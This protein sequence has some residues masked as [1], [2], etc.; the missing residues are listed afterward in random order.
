MEHI[1]GTFKGVRNLGIYY[2]GWLP[3]GE[4]RAVVLIV[5][6]LGEHSGRYA[7][8][9]DCLVPA[10]YAL[11][12]LDHVGHGKSEGDREYVE[13]FEDYIEPLTTYY[14]MVKAWQ[15]DKPM[16]LLGHSL[17]G[18]IA[19]LYLLDHQDDFRGAIFSGPLVKAGESV[20]PV[21]ILMA[22]VLSAVA[23]KAGVAP[24][25]ATGVSRDPAVVKAYVDDP[26]VFHGKTPARTGAELLKAIDRVQAE[27]GRITLPFLTVQGS[28]DKLVD[29]GSAQVLYDGASSEDKTIKIYKGLYHEVFNEPEHE[30]VLQDV[31]RW[32]AAHL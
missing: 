31:E 1:E 28:E 25:D 4:V 3:E 22:R 13:R 27:A 20:S 10:G 7:N 2:Q 6:G 14:D 23:P 17:G 11:Y 12:G 26:L 19:P 15:P 16:F 29:P 9:V 32:L 30:Q 21:A 18:L 8:V 5:H 24:L